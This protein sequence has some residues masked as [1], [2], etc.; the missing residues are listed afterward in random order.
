MIHRPIR[1][2]YSVNFQ[3]HFNVL[4]RRGAEVYTTCTRYNQPCTPANT[5]H[6]YRTWYKTTN[7]TAHSDTCA[8]FARRA[9]KRK[10]FDRR[11]STMVSDADI[12]WYRQSNHVT[13]IQTSW[14]E[15]SVVVQSMCLSRDLL[16]NAIK[17]FFQIYCLQFSNGNVSFH[18]SQ[19][20]Q[21]LSMPIYSMLPGFGHTR[22]SQE[23]RHWN[24][25][26]VS[27]QQHPHT[28]CVIL[29]LQTWSQVV[30]SEP[31][32]S[33]V[34]TNS[35][36]VTRICRRL[37]GDTCSCRFAADLLDLCYRVYKQPSCTVFRKSR[38]KPRVMWF[39]IN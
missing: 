24:L 29:Y 27:Q 37:A 22:T 19:R 32:M 33:L 35:N 15:C 17:Y 10:I 38:A 20:M 21:M 18:G 30:Y 13:Y 34:Q 1:V 5:W 14:E 31:K 9:K 39:E 25:P 11:Q 7:S 36:H 16:S 4:W 12:T 8:N 28:K 6:T 23:K 26:S 3:V 2:H